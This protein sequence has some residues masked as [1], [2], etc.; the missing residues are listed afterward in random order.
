MKTLRT[1]LTALLVI[2]LP[3]CARGLTAGLKGGLNISSFT[4]KD[5]KP[6]GGSII[7]N[8]GFIAGGYVVFP[9][10]NQFGFQ[11]EFLIS[12]KGATYKFVLPDLPGVGD[13]SYET[14]VKLTYL[15]LPLL[16]R[17]DVPSRGAA[18]PNLLFGPAF[19]I[20][21]SARAET[22]SLGA[23]ESG[24]VTGIKTIDPGLVLGGGID[25]G[26]AKGKLTLELRY[27]LGLATIVEHAEGNDDV[28]N[29]AGSFILGYQF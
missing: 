23:A 28:R 27:T 24:S 4:G 19:G 18:K 3:V 8:S 13:M 22:R 2:S 5:A 21:M 11:P 26:T 25:I 20:K 29:S 7:Q 1:I 12:E 15:E 14:S 16:A 10:K 17:Y 6:E 9:V